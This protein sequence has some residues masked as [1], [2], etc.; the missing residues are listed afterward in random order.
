MTI[1]ADKY[2]D[3]GPGLIPNGK[4]ADVKGTA[5][6]FTKA[7]KLGDRIDEPKKN[8]DANGY[9]HCYVLRSQDGKLAFAAK[10][11]DPVTGRVMEISTTEPG[12]QLY[13]AN[14][15]DGGAGNNSYRQHGACCLETQHYPDSPNQPSFPTTTLKPGETFKSTTVHKFSVE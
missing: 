15:F 12:I 2:V 13:T 3:V 8:K 11:K 9:D 10:V 7:T 1:A 4:L 5:L 14:H 6:D